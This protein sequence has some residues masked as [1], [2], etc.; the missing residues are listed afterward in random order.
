MVTRLG[1]TEL[2]SV[3]A[4]RAIYGWN[5]IDMIIFSVLNRFRT[6]G[7][8]AATLASTAD[9][10]VICEYLFENFDA[11]GDDQY[12]DEFSERLDEL[13]RSGWKLVESRKDAGLHRL[14]ARRAV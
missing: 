7:R 10:M 14:V 4:N 5:R 3:V 2:D 6:G 1:R 11:R 13:F 12:L 9:Q 8:E